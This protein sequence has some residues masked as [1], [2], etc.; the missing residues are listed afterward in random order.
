MKQN[1]CSILR[2]AEPAR[3][4][5]SPHHASIRLEILVALY[6]RVGCWYA[7]RLR[8]TSIDTATAGSVIVKRDPRLFP[9][10]SV[11]GEP[12]FVDKDT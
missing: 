2:R 8:R 10:S 4:N 11:S 7:M 9:N 3:W 6:R 12:D 5:I 1:P